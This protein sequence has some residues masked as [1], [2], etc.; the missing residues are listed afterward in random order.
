MVNVKK[1]CRYD[2]CLGKCMNYLLFIVYWKERKKDYN[3]EF[4]NENI[5]EILVKIK[6]VFYIK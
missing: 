1:E 6:L 3:L 2:R 5:D 4:R